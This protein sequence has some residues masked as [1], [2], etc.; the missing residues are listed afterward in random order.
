MVWRKGVGGS[1]P[2]NGGPDAASG[3]LPYATPVSSSPSGVN[4]Q[5]LYRAEAPTHT[6]ARSAAEGEGGAAPAPAWSDAGGV[7]LEQITEHVSRV[8]LRRIAVERERRGVRR[9]L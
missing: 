5:T 8:I 7:S 4:T 3:A 6:L 9:W 1:A 2:P